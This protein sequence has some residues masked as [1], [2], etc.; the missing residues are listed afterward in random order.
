MSKLSEMPVV[1][2]E[3]IMRFRQAAMAAEEMNARQV[4]VIQNLMQQNADLLTAIHPFAKLATEL[5][6]C[7][8]RERLEDNTPVYSCNKAVITIAD[9]KAIVKA[10]EEQ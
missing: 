6:R 3:Q 7:D 1:T 8:G 2:A 10:G 4:Q 9:C 5:M